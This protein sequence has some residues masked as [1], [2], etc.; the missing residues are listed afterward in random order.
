MENF[1]FCAVL[2]HRD[3]FNERREKLSN[4]L[5]WP[6]SCSKY[7]EDFVYR[8]RQVAFLIVRGYKGIWSSS[9]PPP[10]S[11]PVQDWDIRLYQYFR[12]FEGFLVQGGRVVCWHFQH[13]IKGGGI[14]RQST[15]RGLY[16]AGNWLLPISNRNSATFWR[17][18]LT[19]MFWCR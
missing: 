17:P 10:P 9:L 12:K 2:K 7:W 18:C 15:N 14:R 5:Y 11:R 13:K 6:L 3:Q 4:N 8:Q 16:L 19:C 1:I